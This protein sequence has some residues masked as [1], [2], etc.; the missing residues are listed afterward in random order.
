MLL[1]VSFATPDGMSCIRTCTCISSL[2]FL[3]KILFR[4]SPFISMMIPLC[5]FRCTDALFGQLDVKDLIGAVYSV[6]S[7]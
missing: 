3:S 4:F 6:P 7:H 5:V 1:L 2:P